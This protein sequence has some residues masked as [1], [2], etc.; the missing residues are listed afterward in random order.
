MDEKR[1]VFYHYPCMDG[2]A[3]GY[4]AALFLPSD[5][6]FVGIN[7][8]SP[9]PFAQCHNATVYMLDFSL[10]KSDMRNVLGIAKRIVVLD[11]HKTAEDELADLPL[12]EHDIVRFDM[13]RSGCILA[14]QHFCGWEDEPPLML[15]YIEDRDL[16]RWAMPN[17]RL[18]NDWLKTNSDG[19]FPTVARMD[20]MLADHP[21]GSAQKMM[22]E[23]EGIRMHKDSQIKLS[24]AN[25]HRMV[26][27][28]V[29]GLGVNQACSDL[30]SEVAG[31]LAE[32][33]GDAGFGCCYF[34]T[35]RGEWVINL[36]SR[37]SFDVSALAATYGGGGH[38]NAA[39]FKTRDLEALMRKEKT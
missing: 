30:I 31:E 18:I 16:W 23:A 19:T 28:G 20:R 25:G 34:R 17:S 1:I 29:K 11:H 8:G 15:R 12:G 2:L 9:F 7:Y 32:K 39:G 4:V 24:V 21:P 22:V 10:K 5:T 14:W 6:K 38:V 26:I 27:G 13:S 36:R 37:G 3:A 35:N 33:V